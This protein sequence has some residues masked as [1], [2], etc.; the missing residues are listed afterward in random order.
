STFWKSG[1]EVATLWEE[2]SKAM[3]T[4][5]GTD[6]NGNPCGTMDDGTTGTGGSR[7]ATDPERKACNYLHAG[8]TKLYNPTSSTTTSSSSS[9]PLSLNDKNPLLRQTVGCLLLHSYAKKM[10]SEAK[11][12][13]E[14]G[15]SKAFKDAGS[16]NG[17]SGKEPCV[18]CQWKEDIFTT[19]SITTTGTGTETA[20]EKLKGV[21]PQI[22][23][24]SST[25][26]K[27]NINLTPSLCDQLQCAV[28]KW[29]DNQN[30]KQVSFTS[31]TTTNM[32]W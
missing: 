19:C 17:S 23:E 8:L 6:T 13:V 31:S 1:G 29:F 7:Q 2:L 9:G 26:T 3:K 21:Q 24:T 25:T 20:D 16:C 28:P 15:I 18:P 12:L 10:K 32:T 27:E 4:N 5:G 30:N 11:C 22:N 14:S